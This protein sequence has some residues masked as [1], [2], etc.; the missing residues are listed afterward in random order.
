MVGTMASIEVT[1]LTHALMYISYTWFVITCSYSGSVYV[2][3]MCGNSASFLNAGRFDFTSYCMQQ[4]HVEDSTSHQ[5]K[6]G[7]AKEI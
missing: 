1:L 7:G 4:R 3:M 5:G 2:Y 6:G